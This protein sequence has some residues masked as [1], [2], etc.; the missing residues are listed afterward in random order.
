MDGDLSRRVRCKETTEF[1]QNG[2]LS[3]LLPGQFG[4]VYI[5]AQSKPLSMARFPQWQQS[6]Q[7]QCSVRIVKPRV[8]RQIDRAKACLAERVIDGNHVAGRDL[9]RLSWRCRST[10]LLLG[11]GRCLTA[12]STRSSTS[13]TVRARRVDVRLHVVLGQIVEHKRKCSLFSHARV[14]V[15][16]EAGQRTDDGCFERYAPV[17]S[18]AISSMPREHSGRARKLLVNLC[19]WDE[20]DPCSFAERLVLCSLTCHYGMPALGG[21]VPTISAF[22]AWCPELEVRS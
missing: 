7:I 10:C 18:T 11:G 14:V 4:P 20:L 3:C 12:D 9:M 8:V 16:Y 6:N 1:T 17:A 21:V 15:T 13:H 5:D 19:S 2:R 22:T